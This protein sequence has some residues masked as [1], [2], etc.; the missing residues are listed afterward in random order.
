MLA[1]LTKQGFQ[2]RN[3]LLRD[4]DYSRDRRNYPIRPKINK[5]GE[6]EY[7]R[8]KDGGVVAPV[9][10]LNKV[11]KKWNDL[12]DLCEED[13]LAPK[14]LLESAV[15]LGAQVLVNLDKYRKKAKNEYIITGTGREEIG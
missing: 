10:N 8:H 9:N 13:V 14:K 2:V 12:L 5:K 15:Q 4:L 6:V 11:I 3:G 7:V 1:C